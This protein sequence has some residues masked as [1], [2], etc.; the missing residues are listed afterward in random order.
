MRPRLIA[1][2]QLEDG[3]LTKTTQ[4]RRAR[5][6]GDPINTVKLFNEKRADELVLLDVGA[7]RSGCI[8]FDLV[9]E[10]ATEAFM[11]VAYGGG[12]ASARDAERLFGLGVDKVVVNALTVEAPRVVSQIATTYGA[13]ALVASMDVKRTRFGNIE[14]R[15]DRGRTRVSRDPA[16]WA[17]DL[18][19]MGAGEILLTSI[20]REGSR[21]G[22]D[23]ELVAEVSAAVTVPVIAHG[24]AG[25][26][27]DLSAA[28]RA[29]ASAVAAGQ[30]L[31]FHG[32]R[33]AVLV[34]YPGEKELQQA[35][36]GIDADG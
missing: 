2:L 5:Y 19:E 30:M 1:V 14:V 4:F 25:A 23:L 13:Q 35:F 28:V 9:Q 11:P 20:D 18:V 12:I 17:R 16:S 34:T 21:K 6:V 22:L 3:F 33:E 36:E 10:A 26:M 24:G 15:A 32:R 7:S 27:S 8:A 29:G 31:T